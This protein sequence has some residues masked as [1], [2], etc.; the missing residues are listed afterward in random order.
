MDKNSFI[1]FTKT[2]FLILISSFI[3]DKMVYLFI[4]N[5]SKNVL[6]GQKVGKVNHYIT[7]KDTLDFV[8]FGSSRAN[9]HINNLKINKNSFNMGMDGQKIAFH[10]TLIE[11]LPRNK[12]QT[13]LIN[14]DPDEI[15]NK[16]YTGEDINSLKHLF[17][18]N[19]NIK[20]EIKNL[21]KDDFIT[22]FY[23]SSIFN[24]K[25]FPILKNYFLP[26]YN[27]EN[28]FGY[29][30]I[31]VSDNQENFLKLIL[32][33]ENLYKNCQENNKINKIYLDYI[34]FIKS[35]SRKYNKKLI[36]FTSPRYSDNC[37][38][39]NMHFKRLMDKKKIIYYDFTSMFYS[40]N[41]IKYWKDLNHLSNIGADLFTEKL[42]EIIKKY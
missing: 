41:D 29:D 3:I 36:I 15:F 33:E 34:D 20:K 19:E 8:V 17:Y 40:D 31:Y 23:Y 37:N 11:L 14:I 9:H 27:F 26:K 42:R 16:N 25:F 7:I 32:E 4:N 5:L 18:E 22:Y 39:D 1:Y 12:K 24:G 13:I 2:I 10:K 6:S 21:N 35:F 30:P 28:Y 38:N